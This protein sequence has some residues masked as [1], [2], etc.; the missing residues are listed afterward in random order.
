M[1]GLT[2]Q[3]VM[4][5]VN[6]YIGVSGGYLGD[7]SYRTH[8][9]F[10][11]EYCNLEIDP[12]QFKGTTRERFITILKN[13]SPEVQAKIIRGVLKRFPINAEN[14]PTTRTIELYDALLALAR[15]LESASP[16]ASPEPKITS[17]IVERAINDVETLI[18]TSGAVSGVDRIHTAL[19]GYLRA[20]CDRENISYNNDDGMTRLFKILR[21]QHPALQNLGPRSQDIE[22]ILQSFATIMDSLNPIRNTASVAH[23]N[24]KLLGI[25]ESMLVINAARTLLHYFD[26]KFG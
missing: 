5:I 21:Q 4:I 15:R 14:K 1:S 26:A 10:Y 11:L 3:E 19:H 6:Q 8:A 9:D 25:D 2:P 24:A 20:V 7:F 22:R 23:P 13:S 17:A 18:Q 16:V 12:Y